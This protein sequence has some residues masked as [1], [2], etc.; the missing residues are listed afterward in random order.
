[1]RHQAPNWAI[2]L[3]LLILTLGHAMSLTPHASEFPKTILLISTSESLSSTLSYLGYRVSSV[4]C[5]LPGQIHA[6]IV[7]IAG[8][9][10][11]DCTSQPPP[12]EL[13]DWVAG[14]A[15]SGKTVIVD[16]TGLRYMA[17]DDGVSL[18]FQLI[19]PNIASQVPGSATPIETWNPPSDAVML[20]V[21]DM[22]VY[23]VD[24]GGKIF[25]VKANLA[26]LDSGL[27]LELL[28]MVNGQQEHAGGGF[29][30]SPLS[31]GNAIILFGLLSVGS[32]A[33]LVQ[34][35]RMRLG[36]I[37]R[38]GEDSIVKLLV[39]L[40][41]RIIGEEVL[42]HPSRQKIIEYLSSKPYTTVKE[43]SSALK[44]S[45]ASTIWHLSI[46]EREGHVRSV[47]V[48][49]STIYY[50]RGRRREALRSYLESHPAR[51]KII[52]ELS[53]RGLA[54]VSELASAVGLSKSTVK[55]HLDVMVRYGI[56][57]REGGRYKLRD[58]GYS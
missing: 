2:L 4:K 27:V 9:N 20:N 28:S 34:P 25:V 55:H 29:M 12:N 10:P 8:F 31:P 22:E 43:L 1:M 47:D 14:F 15:G 33:I 23:E 18:G 36:R 38:K 46:L 21:S 49:G 35:V 54:G 3:S 13:E 51:A 56:V 11:K 57:V 30:G 26:T 50:K 19:Q 40:F 48:A 41:P 52:M 42:K 32:L 16:E 45:R 24:R 44:A 37:V 53:K 6:D 5:N 39:I 7:V 58:T 17:S